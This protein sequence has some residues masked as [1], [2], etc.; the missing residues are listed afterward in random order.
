MLIALAATAATGTDGVCEALSLEDFPD[1]HVVSVR[2]LT[3]A[4]RAASPAEKRSVAQLPVPPFSAA[5]RQLQ[6]YTDADPSATAAALPKLTRIVQLLSEHYVPAFPTGRAGFS[7]YIP[8]GD[9]QRALNIT[10]LTTRSDL[11]NIF[12]LEDAGVA[13]LYWLVKR[14]FHA[15]AEEYGLDLRRPWYI[16]GWANC[17]RRGD[18]I[19]L[20]SHDT[21]LSG[22]F[23]VHTAP[24][25]HTVY[26]DHGAREQS[27]ASQSVA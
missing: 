7:D 23:G 11:Y 4:I 17:F 14:A 19:R 12:F 22:N 18:G 8:Q 1:E 15:Y 27:T 3:S 13:W 21:R 5:R 26:R 16:H 2:D 20:H 9:A 6:R 10:P 25:S 24:G